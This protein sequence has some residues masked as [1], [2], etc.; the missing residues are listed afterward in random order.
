MPSVET[1]KEAV[2]AAAIGFCA[3]GCGQGAE[4]TATEDGGTITS[5]L[6][7]GQ[8]SVNS[9]PGQML[10]ETTGT[11]FNPG[12]S[13]RQMVAASNSTD[14]GRFDYA[15]TR[16]NDYSS[17]CSHTLFLGSGSTAVFSDP[18][19]TSNEGGT[20][21][22]YAVML[23]ADTT[24]FWFLRS[25]NPCPGVG[26]TCSGSATW[27]T[28]RHIISAMDYPQLLSS[29]TTRDI[30]IL[31][32]SA[33]GITVIKHQYSQAWNTN[34]TVYVAPCSGL[35]G[36]FADRIRG[37]FDSSGVLHIAF[38]NATD[39]IIQHLSMNPT[40]GTWNCSLETVGPV[41]LPPDGCGC[42]LPTIP[43]VGCVRS[44][45]TPSIAIDRSQ[46]PNPMVI[47]YENRSGSTCPGETEMRVYRS[48]NGGASWS[49]R[50][51]TGCH[52]SVMPA[53]NTVAF[54]T[55]SFHIGSLYNPSGT[56]YLRTVDWVSAD[57]GATWNNGTYI[58]SNQ[59][60]SGVSCYAGDYISVAAD[61]ANL[62]YFYTWG[63]STGPDWTVQGAVR[64]Q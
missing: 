21:R 27:D 18:W 22:V 5:Q 14:N 48:T 45:L 49:Y 36:K 53:V 19:L 56:S 43:H 46:S 28:A 38:E 6:T 30:I 29:P 39:R 64:N 1:L 2:V 50:M 61:Y 20:P 3:L 47:S 44:L 17:F 31:V 24:S 62:S 7:V 40:V 37:D 4:T 41:S 35:S 13:G 12:I 9:Q 23:A 60:F 10:T 63:Q 26:T 33:S 11:W 32:R 8:F 34:L 57:S 59:D 42:G 52:T 55:N 51:H 58:S 15:C 54:S 16:T 25:T